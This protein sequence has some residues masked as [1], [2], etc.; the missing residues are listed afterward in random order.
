MLCPKWGR[1]NDEQQLS[2]ICVV[3]FSNSDVSPGVASAFQCARPFSDVDVEDSVSD[4]DDEND[5]SA[6][7]DKACFIA[8]QRMDHSATCMQRIAN[9]S[10]CSSSPLSPTATQTFSSKQA[11][12]ANLFA[13]S[14]FPHA[15]A[16]K[17][18]SP[19]QSKA[20]LQHQQE[21]EVSI[22]PDFVMDDSSLWAKNAA[23][24]IRTA[25]QGTP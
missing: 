10:G 6:H 18:S 19:F 25:L 4:A 16:E 8:S 15:E 21:G 13:R 2:K 1:Q 3:G 23:I 24:M 12:I 20:H 11:A 17:F 9:P 22:V 14:L 5:A 7:C